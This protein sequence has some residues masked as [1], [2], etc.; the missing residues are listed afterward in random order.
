MDV[1]YKSYSKEE[2]EDAKYNVDVNAY[3]ERYAAINAEIA[4]RES[5]SSAAKHSQHEVKSSTFSSDDN[6][7][8]KSTDAQ[9]A[10]LTPNSDGKFTPQKI[11]SLLLHTLFFGG[12]VYL[13]QQ[14]LPSLDKTHKYTTEIH[15]ARCEHVE[16][17][18]NYESHNELILTVYYDIFW[19]PYLDSNTCFNTLLLLKKA[20]K[21]S[22]WHKDGRIY[23]L[24]KGR[25]MLL[26]FEEILEHKRMKAIPD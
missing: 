24:A 5:P 15:D 23:Q 6:D 21:V 9:R 13:T 7:D 11:L 19:L 12:F 20:R 18:E 16:T 22:I 17:T 3:P 1:D 4:R 10:L 2:L 14:S 8:L 26:T 25:I